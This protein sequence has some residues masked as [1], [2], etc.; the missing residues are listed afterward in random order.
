MEPNK[1]RRQYM[2]NFIGALLKGIKIVSVYLGYAVQIIEG[3]MKFAP[4]VVEWVQNQMDLLQ[5]QVD[6]SNNSMTGDEARDFIVEAGMKEFTG[7]GPVV[8]RGFLRT[9]VDN[10]HMLRKAERLG[11]DPYIDREA[12][13]VKKGYIKSE[14]LAMARKAMPYF[15]PLD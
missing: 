4:L 3:F 10:L 6:D 12:L 14:D 1:F 8:T 13:A 7:S 5:S 2:G 9:I 15:Q 11:L